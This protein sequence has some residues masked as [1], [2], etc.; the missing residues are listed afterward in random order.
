[1]GQKVGSDAVRTYFTSYAFHA[2]HSPGF[3]NPILQ[4]GVESC[5]RFPEAPNQYRYLNSGTYMGYVRHLYE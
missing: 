2:P 4:L 1:M 5:A 3:C